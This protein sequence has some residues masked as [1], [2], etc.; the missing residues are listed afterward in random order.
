MAR[1]LSIVRQGATPE[2]DTV[3]T[4]AEAARECLERILRSNPTVIAFLSQRLDEPM[5]L[6]SLPGSRL[7]LEGMIGGASEALGMLALS[8]SKED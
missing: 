1:T 2:E 8:V 7:V 4:M 6:E 5:Q 3:C